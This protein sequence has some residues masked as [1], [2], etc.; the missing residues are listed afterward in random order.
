MWPVVLAF[1]RTYAPY[2]LFPI[3]ATIGF[4]G[5]MYE[6]NFRQINTPFKSITIQEERDQRKLEE[7]KN[8]TDITN[9]ESL[10]SK[11]NVPSSILDRNDKANIK[12]HDDPR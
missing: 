7:V 11:P 4:V 8:Q 10:K 2:V 3:T 6:S 5:Y 9:L 1:A 12:K